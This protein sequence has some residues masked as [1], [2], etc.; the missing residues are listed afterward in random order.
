MPSDIP[1]EPP[2]PQ[3]PDAP[4]GEALE[5]AIDRWL[6]AHPLPRTLRPYLVASVFESRP[7]ER[8]TAVGTSEDRLPDWD[9]C[10]ARWSARTLDQAIAEIWALAQDAP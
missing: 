4:S 1:T 3:G 5:E 10:F 8:A 2:P 7:A 9:R 6:T